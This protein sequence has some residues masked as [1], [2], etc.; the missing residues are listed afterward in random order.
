MRCMHEARMHRNNSFI[1]LTYSDE[2]YTASLNHEDW[3]DFI[4]RLRKRHG[5]TRYFMCGEYGG[6]TLRPHYHA[7]LFGRVFD[8]LQPI[9]EKLWRSPTLERLWPK[10]Y[11]SV[12][13]VNYQSARYVAGYCAKEL[14]GNVTPIAVDQL[15][16]E[17]VRV[18]SE[19]GK[20]SRNPGLGGPWWEKY[21]RETYEA[22]DGVV[23]NGKVKPTPRYYDKKLE[24]KDK[25]KLDEIKTQRLEKAK[26]F[27]SDTT[28]ERLRVREKCA[29][30]KQRMI[31]RQL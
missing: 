6:Q 14:K 25:K 22:R 2:H 8:D 24:I 21:G 17:Y 27:K 3:Q 30:A 28:E 19:Y 18:K 31:K 26:E 29:I 7:L 12:G 9:G 4:R 23:V 11:S 16:G 13:E 10:G 1:T 5:K 20:M 15:T